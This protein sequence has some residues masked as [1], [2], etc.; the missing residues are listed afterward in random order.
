MDDPSK[1]KGQRALNAPAESATRHITTRPE[2][3][4]E[5]RGAI[6]LVATSDQRRRYTI[7][8]GTLHEY[9]QLT[10]VDDSND[11]LRAGDLIITPEA[12]VPFADSILEDAGEDGLQF[13]PYHFTT[14]LQFLECVVLYERLIIGVCPIYSTIPTTTAEERA[15]LEQLLGR[16]CLGVIHRHPAALDLATPITDQLRQAGVL[17][18]RLLDLPDLPARTHFEQHVRHSPTLQES[19]RDLYDRMRQEKYDPAF[20]QELATLAAWCDNG[21]PLYAAEAARRANIPF[22]AG[23]IE[24]RGLKH[25]EQEEQQ[26]FTTV[27][28]Q[29]KDRL[30]EGAQQELQRIAAFGGT[31]M[32]PPT[33]IAWEI[34]KNA[35][36]IDDLTT[37][38]LHLRDKYKNV[39]RT[40]QDLDTDL[41]SDEITTER[42]TKIVK[43]LDR[44]VQDL[45]PTQEH[46]FRRDLIETAALIAAVPLAAPSTPQGALALVGEIL[47]KPTEFVFALLRRHKYRVLFNAQRE[48]LNGKNSVAKI[49][50]LL[51]VDRSVVSVGL[52]KH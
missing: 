19:T 17:S 44:L 13:I 52:N 10:R 22:H 29:L 28:E 20:H 11:R 27:V 34:M 14:L 37:S 15:H 2:T 25:L 26:T 6:P 38:A 32:Y 30:N 31:T 12:A 39:R 21:R 35:T 49:A 8:N 51:D 16:W 18:N 42:K 43:E 3:P 40:M 50:T 23:P 45:W 41:R 24:A 9:P 33:P 5:S 7:D 47:G 4:S 36:T 46:G 48:F 1:P